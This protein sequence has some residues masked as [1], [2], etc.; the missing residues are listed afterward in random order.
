[1]LH[2]PLT[3]IV[4]NEKPPPRGAQSQQVFVQSLDATAREAAPLVDLNEL[5]LWYPAGLV[6][7]LPQGAEQG[8]YAALHSAVDSRKG[9]PQHRGS[10]WLQG[11]GG[12]RAGRPQAALSR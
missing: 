8:L 4:G 11:R 7:Q 1:M 10:S 12:G 9:R 6:R 3:G 5:S 2:G